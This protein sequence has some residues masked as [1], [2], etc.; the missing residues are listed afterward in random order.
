MTAPFAS[1][2]LHAAGH[3]GS[4]TGGRVEGRDVNAHRPASPTA[5]RAAA[6][7]DRTALRRMVRTVWAPS[8]RES[9]AGASALQRASGRRSAGAPCTRSGPGKPRATKGR[10]GGSRWLPTAGRCRIARQ[11]PTDPAGASSGSW[12]RRGAA[13]RRCPHQVDAKIDVTG[14]GS[15]AGRQGH[16]DACCGLADLAARLTDR[17][18][19]PREGRG[20]TDVVGADDGDLI[21]ARAVRLS[22]SVR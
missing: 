2:T 6:A 1:I 16:H 20:E 18:E 15:P 3:A 8:P 22:G 7:F 14:V 19:R 13:R 11:L 21:P 10:Q 5:T 9:R 4:A 17:G 12:G